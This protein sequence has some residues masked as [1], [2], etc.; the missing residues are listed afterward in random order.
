MT[1]LINSALVR[2]IGFLSS[3]DEKLTGSPAKL[4]KVKRTNA[5]IARID[6]LI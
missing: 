3:D 5:A 4:P 2:L 6:F 1:L